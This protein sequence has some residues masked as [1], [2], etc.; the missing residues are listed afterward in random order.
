M[1]ITISNLKT[2]LNTYLGDSSQDRISDTERYQA[3]TEATTWLLE[4]LGNEH[5]VDT[6]SI[7]FLDTVN[8]YKVTDGLADL[9]V[10]GDLRLPTEDHVRSFT[11]KSPREIAEEIGQKQTGDPSW[12]IERRDGD[13]FLVI[14]YNSPKAAQFIT[15]LDSVTDGG[16]WTVD[17]DAVNITSDVNEKKQ[18]TASLNFDIDVSA[19]GSNYAGVYAPDAPVMDISQSEQLGSFLMDVY[20]PDVSETTAVTLFWGSDEGATPATRAD[21]WSSTVTT[22]INGNAFVDGWNTVRFNWNGATTT[23][24]P[25]SG[26]VGYYEVRISYG[27][28]QGDDTDYR[29]DNLRLAMPETLTFHYVSWNVGTDNSF[30]DITSYTADTDIPFYSGR[31]D[32]YRYAVAHKAASILFYSALRLVEQGAVEESEAA[33]A[34]QRYRENFESNKTRE[35][36]SFKVHGVNL[37]QRS[38]RRKPR[39]S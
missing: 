10:G 24:T 31:Y 22:D 9:L 29:L 26:A 5:M 14:N 3:L 8:T 2:N 34:L 27:A 28:G 38:R 17:A 11:R 12:A 36:K 35:I 23:G 25:N 32:Q 4:E 13:A 37:R 18:G 19:S 1:S 15:A 21:Y 6:Y 39:I 20:I 30:A 7:D 33:K 16:T